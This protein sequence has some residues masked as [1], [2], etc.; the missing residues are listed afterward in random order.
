VS[1]QNIRL[2]VPKWWQFSLQQ[3]HV[4]NIILHWLLLSGRKSKYWGNCTK[5]QF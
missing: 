4:F 1:E 5:T 2:N 3:N